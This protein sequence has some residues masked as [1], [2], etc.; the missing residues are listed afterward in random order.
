M[1]ELILNRAS[2][3]LWGRVLLVLLMGVGLY[4]TIRLRALPLRFLPY[5]LRLLWHSRSPRPDATGD[6]S[7]FQALMTELSAT[8]GTGNIAG[9]A[10]A[11]FLGG[12]GAVFWM[13]AAALLGMAT[14]Y[15]ESVLAVRFREVDELG[16]CVGGPMYYIKNG[17][18]GGWAWLGAC[19]SLFAMIA[20]FGIGNTV[21]SNTVAA[22]LESSFSIPPWLSGTV[23]AL[24]T[25]AVIIGGIH[26]LA[27][28]AGR[29]VPLM[30]LAYVAVSALVIAAHLPD[31]PATLAM[32]ARDAL[33]G[34]AAAGGFAG[35]TT[36]AAI[37]YGLARGVFSNEAGL[38]STPIAHAAAK[39]RDPV[40]QGMISM[41]G[42][43]IDTIVVCTM[44][45]LV[46]LLTGAWRS[47]ETGAALSKTAFSLGFFGLGGIVVATA[48]SIFAFTTLLGWSYYGERCA[49]FLLGVRVIRWYR[50]LW[51]LAIPVGAMADLELIW[52]LAD[53][54][55]GLM[56]IPNLIALAMLSPLIFDL[57][58]RGPPA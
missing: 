46:I 51:V 12:P 1:L 25:G 53:V 22:A 58:R 11:I 17:L 23:I 28:V 48:L 10:T 24:L 18:G 3:V 42:P 32:I 19:F 57:T 13:W 6:I 34:S 56:A 38:G 2:E 54:L 31:V 29:L 41:L 35:T 30:A 39:T 14:K 44:T 50:L 9:V 21:Q 37:Q 4:L 49:E 33:T 5:A 16:H 40:Q 27:E 15:G 20:A 36:M 45:A 8:V 26:R 7:P 55:N 43:F 52:L 47:G